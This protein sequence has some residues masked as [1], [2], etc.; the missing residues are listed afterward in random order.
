MTWAQMDGGGVVVGLFAN[1]QPSIP[2]VVALADNDP[3]MVAFNAK[4]TVATALTAAWAAGCQIQSA[5]MPVLNTLWAL[6]DTTLTEIGSVARDSAAGLGLPLGQA[7]FAYP[8][9]HGNQVVCT[10]AQVQ[11]LYKALRDY[12]AV[13]TAFSSGRSPQPPPQPWQ[14]P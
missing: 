7:A 10:P 4:A 8:D 5:A 14:I 1:P 13:Y 2:G 3:R 6:D 9:M 12:V 11:A